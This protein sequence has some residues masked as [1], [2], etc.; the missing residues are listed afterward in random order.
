LNRRPALY[1]SA[2]LPL[3]YVGLDRAT[4]VPQLTAADVARCRRL[5]AEVVSG[6]ID[7]AEAER[8]AVRR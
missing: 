1:E 3:S 7:L 8:R 5:A 2:A 6:R 4:S